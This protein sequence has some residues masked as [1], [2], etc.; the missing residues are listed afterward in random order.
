MSKVSAGH[1]GAV[2][3]RNFA[4]TSITRVTQLSGTPAHQ[5]WGNLPV[6]NILIE[7]RLLS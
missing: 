3:V 4:R 1:F 2:P 6:Y 5:R 7:T